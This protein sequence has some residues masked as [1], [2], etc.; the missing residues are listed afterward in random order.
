MCPCPQPEGWMAYV[1][2][3][4]AQ[5]ASHGAYTKFQ[6]FATCSPGAVEDLQKNL[7]LSSTWHAP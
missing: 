5:E 1:L 6:M 3:Q 7:N 2:N 4:K